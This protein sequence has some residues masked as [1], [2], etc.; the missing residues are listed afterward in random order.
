MS[1]AFPGLPDGSCLWRQTVNGEVLWQVAQESGPQ[2]QFSGEQ[3]VLP[4]RQLVDRNGNGWR[5]EWNGSELLHIREFT[6][7][8][9]DRA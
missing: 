3:G 9:D 7:Q 6:H 8:G 2:L 5:F 1:R 4:I